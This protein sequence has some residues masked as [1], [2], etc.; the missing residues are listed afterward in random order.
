MRDRTTRHRFRT[1]IS[2]LMERAE[3]YA[4]GELDLD[5]VARGWEVRRDS[6][7]RRTYRD[8]RW[9]NV[10]EC[11]SCHGSGVEGADT[12]A[13]CEGRGTVRPEPAP[14]AGAP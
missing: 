10:L 7:F 4:F 12:C 11:P 5:A 3:R 14:L 2:A 6:R 1:W 9:D 8:P 13:E